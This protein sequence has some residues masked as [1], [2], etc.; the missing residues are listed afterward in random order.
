LNEKIKDFFIKNY[1]FTAIFKKMAQIIALI[2]EK[3]DFFKKM[4]LGKVLLQTLP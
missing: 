4:G 3:T 2:L 1:K